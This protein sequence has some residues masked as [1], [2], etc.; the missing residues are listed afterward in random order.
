MKNVVSPVL[1]ILSGLPASGKS[2]LSKFIAKRYNAVYLRIDTV[3]QG[4]RDLFKLK[5]EGEGYGL[6]YKIASDN[7]EL[8]LN[9]V[10]DSCNSINL[11]RKQWED[12]AK[13]KDCSFIN[14]E[15]ICSNKNE[16]KKHAGTRKSEVKNL[17]LP[18][19]ASIENREHDDWESERIVIDTSDKTV[20]NTI[21]ELYEKIEGYLN[22]EKSYP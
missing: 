21:N 9:V 8:G 10:A 12:V 4:L 13:S 18:S 16:H 1:F 11:T 3:E 19:W 6:S 22:E 2:T 20:N 14:I 5:V 15:V 7:L 17:K